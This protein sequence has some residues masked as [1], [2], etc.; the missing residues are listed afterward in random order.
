M[1]NYTYTCMYQIHFTMVTHEEQW[2][3]SEEPC[4]L[5]SPDCC[6][7]LIQDQKAHMIEQYE[8]WFM[9]KFALRL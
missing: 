1:H 3:A 7:L 8:T 2:M 4:A 9:Y 5:L 6:V